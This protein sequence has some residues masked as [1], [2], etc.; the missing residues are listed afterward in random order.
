[1][2]CQYILYIYIYIKS[3]N[4]F[5]S[6]GRDIANSDDIFTE[7]KNPSLTPL[8]SER[9]TVN[10]SINTEVISTSH[11]YIPHTAFTDTEQIKSSIVK[12]GYSPK[13]QYLL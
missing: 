7:K 1:M 4:K 8:E 11:N 9:M 6:I 13:P 12:L 2:S 10:N 5:I 3:A